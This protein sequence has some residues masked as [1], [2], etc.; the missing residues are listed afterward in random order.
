M[1]RWIVATLVVAAL[2]HAAAVFGAPRLVMRRIMAGVAASAG[3]WNA[4]F[5]GPRA[6]AASRQIVMPSP[7]LLYTICAFDLSNGPVRLTATPPTGTYWSAAAYAANTDNFFVVSDRTLN[8]RTLDTVLALEGQAAP[9]GATVVRAPSPRGIVLYRTL[10]ADEAR[11][12][13]LDAAR[14]AMRCAP[15]S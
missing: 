6:S 5:A 4:A 15:V 14:K 2:V 13:E 10:I 9:A 7:D 12:P 11:L 8:A 3:G 1:I